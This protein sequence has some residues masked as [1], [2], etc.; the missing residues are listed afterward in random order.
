MWTHFRLVWA[1]FR[2]S[3][4]IGGS[5]AFVKTTLWS[6]SRSRVRGLLRSLLSG[7]RPAP[8]RHL[9]LPDGRSGAHAP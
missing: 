8:D 9:P 5:R 2:G 3:T 1:P 4:K 7:A 6:D